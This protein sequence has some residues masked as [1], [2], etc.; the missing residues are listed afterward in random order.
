M[1]AKI[2]AFLKK[3]IKYVLFIGSIILVI[4][5]FSFKQGQ[6]KR[7][8]EKINTLE[9]SNFALNNDRIGLEFQLKKLQL[10]YSA[11]NNSNDSLKK[12]LSQYQKELRDLIKSHA[13]EL[14]ELSKV[15]DDTAFKR[16][17]PIYPNYDN[18][19]LKYPFSG[20]Q[21]RGIYS[22]VTSY[23]MIK[24]EYTLQT[25]SLSTC[26]GLNAGYESGI[27]NLNKQI[28][29]LQSNVDKADLQMKNYNKERIVLNRQID[30][31]AFW[32]KV[33]SG[34][35]AAAAIVAIFK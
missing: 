23:N 12:L 31:K 25:K 35:F 5:W 24:Q 6:I 17:Q 30:K 20:S 13:Q 18:G 15:P 7:L 32:N 9:M 21:I 27:L 10:D 1:K 28:V 16:L 22:G 8:T 19:P 2:L 4:L 33:L 11:I 29:N 3:N 34:G 14:A 26:L